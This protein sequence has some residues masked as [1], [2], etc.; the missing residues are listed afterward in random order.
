M[1][2]GFYTNTK[3]FNQNKLFADSSHLPI[4]DDLLYP[5]FYISEQLKKMGHRVSTI[6]MDDLE[7][8]DA[9][10]FL[11]FPGTGNPY[12]KTLVSRG[13]KNLYLIVYESPIIKPD[14]FQKE[15]YAYFKKVFTWQDEIVDNKQFFKIQYSHKIPEQL[16][17]TLA[18]NPSTSS[19]QAKKL[20]TI[21]SSN[22]SMAHPKEL[23][24]E[25]IKAIRWFE[26]NH[27]EN[28]DLYGNGWDRYHF[29]GTFFGFKIARLNRL[30]FLTKL[31][32][33][34]YPSWKGLVPSKR[35]T[36]QKYRF[37]I[38][39]ENCKGF[40]GYITEKIFDCLLA[41][42]VPIYLGAPNISD[43]I[44]KDTFID[45]RNFATY[46]ELYAYIKNMP[47]Q[48]YQSYLDAIN[49]FLKSDKARPFSAKYFADTIIQQIIQ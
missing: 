22:K 33:P 44:P 5:F 8:F 39:Y 34:Y 19:G 25:R 6:D 29:E 36:Y 12:F 27:P 1:Y 16:D 3:Q 49:H 30:K 20:C 4:G 17:F 46:Q 45:K 40:N 48:K 31:L 37:S 15:N 18:Q 38:C 43:H 42:C 24:T 41:G 14:N 23:Y 26:Q 32:R 2:I 9:V 35:K 47:G 28:F 7:K 11:D 13:H 21:I 10:V